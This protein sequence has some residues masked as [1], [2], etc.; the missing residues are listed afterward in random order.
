M[1]LAYATSLF[2]TPDQWGKM[3]LSN[4]QIGNANSDL[5]AS[6]VFC[7]VNLFNQTDVYRYG[8]GNGYC[9]D[10]SKEQ[11]GLSETK[12]GILISR[13]HVKRRFEGI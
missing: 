8:T 5:K 13:Y 3:A 10:T 6:Y 7:V 2:D 9:F 11:N 4:S 1:V 12:G